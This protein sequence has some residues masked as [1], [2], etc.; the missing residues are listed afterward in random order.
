M[1]MCDLSS[2]AS[3]LFTHVNVMQLC[4][5]QWKC[6]FRQVST[7]TLDVPNKVKGGVKQNNYYLKGNGS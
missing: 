6:T 3:I 1:F 4:M 2:I 7:R 5:L